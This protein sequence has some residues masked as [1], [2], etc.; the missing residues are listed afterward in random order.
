[1]SKLWMQ[2]PCFVCGGPLE[3]VLDPVYD[4][5]FGAESAYL[6]A[7]CRACHMTQTLP[8]PTPEELGKLYARFYNFGGERDTAY[9]RLRQKF[10]NS[11]AYSLFLKLDGDI[12]FHSRRG[13]GRLLDIGCN[14]GRGLALY[15][16]NGFTTVEGLETNPV[17]AAAARNR[18]FSIH[19]V[20]LADF[21]P[22]QRYDVAVLSNV[23]EHALDPAEMLGQ[24]ARI[25]RPGG[26][27]WISCPNADSWARHVFKRSWINWH[28][29]FHIVH[30]TAETLSDT[31]KRA[32]FTPLEQGQITPALWIAHSILAALF[33]K[34]GEATQALRRPLLVMALM[35]LT[36][37]LFFPLLWLGNRLG[38]GDCLIAVARAPKI[39]G[40]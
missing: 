31:V 26:E 36:R 27:V 8:R 23:L 30:F 37:G 6:I 5:R 24:V 34:P 29:P 18:G 16:R 40:L 9:T 32:H 20:E 13:Q 22:E 12:S 2:D 39:V 3:V 19:E 10:L 14:E 38:K 25:L 33:A 17:A 7:E 11:W 35:A 1:M 28:V 4:T 15:A 21:K